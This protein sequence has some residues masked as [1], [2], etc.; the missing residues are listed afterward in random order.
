MLHLCSFNGKVLLSEVVDQRLTS[1]LVHQQFLVTGG[2]ACQLLKGP[3]QVKQGCCPDC[4]HLHVLTKY[5]Y[6]YI[7]IC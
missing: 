2:Q 4:V 3:L 1:L 6:N 5:P 7:L